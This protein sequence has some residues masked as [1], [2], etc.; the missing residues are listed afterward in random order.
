MDIGLG[1][2]L[3]K[4]PV[5]AAKEATRQAIT[6]IHN[7]EVDLAIVF[8]SVDL[9]C[10]TLLKTVSNFLADVPIIGCSG[11][12]IISGLG[13]F[14]HGLIV[15][16]LNFPEEVFFNTACVNQIEQKTSLGAGRELAEKLLY[17]FQG[18][19]RDLSIIFCDGLIKEGSKF[20]FGLQERLGR[21]FPL[22]GASAS[23]N[24]HFLRTYLYFNQEV[25]SDAACGLLWGGKLNFGLGIKHGWKPL[26]KPR[27]VTK[28][29]GNIVYEIDGAPAANV[30]KEYLACDFE[31]LKK[32]LKYISVLYPIGIYLPGEEEYLLRNILAVE[33]NGALVFQ[34]DVPQGSLI[35]LM[36]GTKESCLAATR[37]AAEEAKRDLT[38]QTRGRKIKGVKNFVLVFDSVSRYILLGR[39][40]KKE[41][42]IIQESLGKDTPVIGLYTYGEQAPL[43]AVSYQGQTHFHNQTMVILN[44]E[45]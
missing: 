22:V 33:D 27:D 11:A 38:I 31:R 34:G 24:L 4:E 45:G 7:T 30:Y 14:K 17:A 43:R 3:E 21:S 9:A 1:L 32:E 41:L 44:I 10:D 40:A 42:E 15:M 19:R 39:D 23:D 2:S 20:I 5:S 29:Y 28:S 13:I 6:N 35:R 36:I 12:A 37:Q 16:L 18:L 25:L 26:G 8:S